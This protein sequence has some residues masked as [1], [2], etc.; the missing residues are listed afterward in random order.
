VPE[1]VVHIEDK[2]KNVQWEPSDGENKGDGHKQ[3]VPPPQPLR[4][5]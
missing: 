5:N 1:R 2:V 4:I 3:V